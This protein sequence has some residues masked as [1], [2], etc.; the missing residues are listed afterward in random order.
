MRTTKQAFSE[1]TKK[2]RRK[3][4]VVMLDF[5]QLW[6]FHTFH[7][8]IALQIIRVMLQCNV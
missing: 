6:V 2:I 1:L 8:Q 4:F 5:Q 3:G 7:N